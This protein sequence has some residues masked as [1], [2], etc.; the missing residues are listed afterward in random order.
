[1][2]T[3]LIFRA[4][5]YRLPFYNVVFLFFDGTGFPLLTCLLVSHV[6]G[7]VF[8]PARAG[9]IKLSDRAVFEEI[10]SS[11]SKHAELNHEREILQN[12]T[13]DGKVCPEEKGNVKRHVHFKHITRH[14]FLGFLAFASS[15]FD[16]SN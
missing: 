13:V 8:L 15:K 7:C 9:I 2:I 5:V 6:A 10:F 12:F 11:V 3:K 14:L 1:M 4:I 16:P